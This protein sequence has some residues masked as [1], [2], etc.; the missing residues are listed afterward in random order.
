MNIDKVTVPKIIAKKA[1]GE[2]ISCVTAYD[3]PSAFMADQAGVDM[4]LVGDS[5]GNTILGYENTLPV[6][7]DEMRH[8]S[9][10][11]IRAA[12][13]SLVI[14]DLPFLSYQCSIEEGIKNAGLFLKDGCTAVKL[15]CTPG[16][17]P[18][19][20]KLV[21]MGIPVMG[22]LGLTPQSVHVMGGYKMQ[23][24]TQ[25]E[26][27]Q[28]IHDAMTLESLGI[29]SLV[30]EMVPT[31]VAKIVTQRL[32]IPT[33]GIGAGPECDGQVL[34]FADLM[35]YSDFVPHHVK[36]YENLKDRMITALKQYDTDVKQG[37]FPAK[38]NS[39]EL[40][41]EEYENLL[42]GLETRFESEF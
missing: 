11:V 1:A 36:R 24:K 20:K 15:E 40:D 9:R 10:A 35:G 42:K 8:H 4:I 29:F 12:K 22:H 39:R 31:Q 6:T 13:R 23:A 27:T 3:Y 2:K 21:E 25:K 38:E 30:L 16:T 14:G 18:L 37:A 19:V 41:P 17:F 26:A 5:L 28:L 34:V 7:M 33:I 32:S